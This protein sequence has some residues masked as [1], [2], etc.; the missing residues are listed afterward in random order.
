MG[1]NT[2]SGKSK[3]DPKDLDTFSKKSSNS[4][5]KINA[6][7]SKK[8]KGLFLLGHKLN[9]RDW[10][11]SYQDWLQDKKKNPKPGRHPTVDHWWNKEQEASQQ[12]KEIENSNKILDTWERVETNGSQ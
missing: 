5:K 1:Q 4:K 7:D 11:V 12:A 10:E 2:C 8:Q 9:T 6:G 3:N